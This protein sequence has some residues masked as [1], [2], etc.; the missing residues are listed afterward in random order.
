MLPDYLRSRR[1]KPVPLLVIED[2]KDHQLLIGYSLRAKMPQTK[3]VFAE[4][5]EEALTH[6]QLTYDE[7]NAFPRLVLLDLYLPTLSQ[8]WQVLT[9]LRTRYPRLPIIILSSHQTPSLVEK[10]YELGAHSFLCKPSSIE[11]W[12]S[13]FRVLNEYWF[14]TITLPPSH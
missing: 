13:S 9:E 4:T 10:A 1:N 6:L 12:E 11:D 7:P 14:S 8:G 2:N 5:P 3:P